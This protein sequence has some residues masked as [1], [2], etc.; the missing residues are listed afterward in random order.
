MKVLIPTAGIGSRLGD[1]TSHYNKAMLPIGKRPVISYVIDLYPR[2][3][4]FVIALGYKGDYIRQYLELVYPNTKITFIDIDNFDGPGSGLG[5]TLRQCK[6]YLDQEFIFHANDSIVDD[7]FLGSPMET[8]AMFLFGDR[9]DPKKYRTVSVD[10]D[11]N[12]VIQI[13]DKTETPLQNVFN[14]IGVAYIKNYKDFVEILE[15]ISV[16]IGESDYF[17][18]NLDKEIR[19][20]FVDKW[21]DIGNIEQ[22]R[23]ALSE[24]A[25]FKNLSKPD[26][27]IYFKGTRV[28]KFSTNETFIQKRVERASLLNGLVPE[29]VAKSKNFYV[30]DYIPGKLLSEE[31]SVLPDFQL[32]LNWSLESLWKPIKLNQTNQNKFEN[33]CF[34]F[35]YEK[36]MDRL[37]AFYTMYDFKDK[38]EEINGVSTP[39]L[40]TLL[41]MIDWSDL[42]RGVPVLFHGDYHFENILRTESE[43]RLLDWRQGF[44]DEIKYGDLYY[45]LAKL[46]HGLIVNHQIIRDEQFTIQI[47]GRNA[48]FD[49]HRK[50]SLIECEKYFYN[51]VREN[52][53]SWK[54]TRILTALI[55]LNIA[56]LHHYPYS[57]FLYYLGKSMLWQIFSDKES[58]G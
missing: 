11:T 17:M 58:K 5:Y 36:T 19:A 24:L 39:T 45:D 27:A 34:Q 54:R 21:Y 44:G 50:Y 42:K 30:Y 32:L 15:D 37:D 2:N 43:F 4:E 46:L 28:Y 14:Y 52:D 1:L 29:I 49:F 31:V 10:S 51:F 57:H 3:T 16:H 33:T 20:Y 13:H 9:P 48:E 53:W 40:S 41:E 35:Y 55:Y 56:C 47:E 12:R 8:D 25:D 7:K 18:R 22:Y 26:E 38:A 6:P 23:L